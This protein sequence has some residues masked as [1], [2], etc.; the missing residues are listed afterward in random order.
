[1]FSPPYDNCRLRSVNAPERVKQHTPT[2]CDLSFIRST[3]IIEKMRNL[4]EMADLNASR[5]APFYTITNV[6]T[7]SL[8]VL[9][10]SAII[11]QP[12]TCPWVSG[13]FRER[14]HLCQTHSQR[15][16]SGK[17]SAETHSRHQHSV[18]LLSGI[19]WELLT[20]HRGRHWDNN[21]HAQKTKTL[22]IS[23]RDYLKKK[24]DQSWW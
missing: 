23:R 13:F 17:S 1:M 20:D 2:A 14:R 16:N 24:Y 7:E 12:H 8:W 5:L 9:C 21:T 19:P 18:A 15:R 4:N 6:R 11:A 22:C 10:N 3:L